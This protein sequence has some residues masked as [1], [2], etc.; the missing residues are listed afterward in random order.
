MSDGFDGGELRGA[1]PSV[2]QVARDKARA[3]IGQRLFGTPSEPHR[4]GRF[5]IMER[6]GRG[7]M[8][9]VYSAYDPMLDR[10]VALKLLRPRAEGDVEGM[11]ARLQREAQALARLSHPNVVPVY[12]IGILGDDVFIVMEFVVGQTLRAWAPGRPWHEVLAAYLQ[13]ARGLAAAH[14]V[15]LVHRDIKPD[16]VMVGEDGRVRLLDFG[17]VRGHEPEPDIPPGRDGS[18]T[19]V[20][21]AG[22]AGISAQVGSLDTVL[23]PA[24]AD[25]DAG[26]AT[27]IEETPVVGQVQERLTA[28]AAIMGTPA[29]MAPEQLRGAGIGPKSDQFGFCAALYEALHGERLSAAVALT[30]LVNEAHALR[31]ITPDNRDITFPAPREPPVSSQLP[32][33]LWPILR[34]GLAADPAQRWPS[35]DALIDALSAVLARY[36]RTL[37]DPRVHRFYRLVQ[38]TVA[39]IALFVLVSV[40]HVSLRGRTAEVFTP[41]SSLM[42]NSIM[43]LIGCAF[44]GIVRMRWKAADYLRRLLEMF[45][46][47]QG[48]MLL[49]DVVGLWVGRPLYQTMLSDLVMLAAVFALGSVLFARW[50]VW[51]LVTTL[52]ALALCLLVPEHYLVFATSSAVLASI[53]TLVAWNRRKRQ[54]GALSLASQPNAGEPR[55]GRGQRP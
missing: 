42:G 50:M 46:V 2:D 48:G 33:A 11:R 1:Q 31:V 38:A 12:D 13:A 26:G 36:D 8:G 51:L 9:V 55:A 17:L 29:Y 39:T 52:A 14:A 45:V 7:G 41:H 28:T 43:V 37:A 47:F 30:E 54:L 19:D 23:V 16:N 49:N 24:G 21:A 3:E 44:V 6:L 25:L 15:G 35:M 10:R 34:R 20:P 4:L 22:A 5:V 18:A 53:V 27:S 40:V 32:A